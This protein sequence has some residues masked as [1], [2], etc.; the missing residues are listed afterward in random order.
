MRTPREKCRISDVETYVACIELIY[1]YILINVS[2]S[3]R[4]AARPDNQQDSSQIVKN[5][6]II[7]PQGVIFEKS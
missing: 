6:P 4:V 2:R 3:T 5:S 7:H 1:K